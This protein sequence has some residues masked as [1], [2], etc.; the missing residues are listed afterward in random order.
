MK[1]PNTVNQRTETNNI[2]NIYNNLINITINIKLPNIKQNST[3]KL[4]PYNTNP[5]NRCI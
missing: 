1:H 2:D 3:A 5:T 4:S